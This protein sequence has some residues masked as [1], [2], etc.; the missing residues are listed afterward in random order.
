MKD[1]VFDKVP[2][3]HHWYDYAPE[4]HHY[5]LYSHNLLMACHKIEDVYRSMGLARICLENIRAEDF[6]ELIDGNDELSKAVMRST[7]INNSIS[8]YNYCIDLSWQV[9]WLYYN[10]NIIEY[11]IHKREDYLNATKDCNLE[12]LKLRLALAKQNKLSTYAEDFFNKKTTQCIRKKYNYIKHR[13]IYHIDGLGANDKESLLNHNG[14][15]LPLLYR[16]EL[17]LDN[18]MSELIEFDKSFVEYFEF[19]IESVVPKDYLEC[20]ECD[21]NDYIKYID[22]LKK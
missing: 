6:G 22:T 4:E 3:I 18:I 8:Y 17:N 12:G 5:C 16:E 15:K 14:F 11:S 20:T 2:N 9:L 19:I 21:M 7:L 13:G 1:I 10:P